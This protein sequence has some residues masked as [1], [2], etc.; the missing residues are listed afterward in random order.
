MWPPSG[1]PAAV[2]K[3]EIDAGAGSERAERGA[4]EGFLGE[5]GV[6]VGG[7]GIERGEA[8]AG[9]AERIAFAE[10]GGDAGSFD[11]DAANAAAIGEADEGS[12]LLDDA[13]EHGL[14]LGTEGPREQGTEK[15]GTGN[16]GLRDVGTK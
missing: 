15:T 12:G 10:A 4:V 2:G 9:D 7:V 5:V 16:K 13:G 11:G 6:E 1:L 14:I 8:D 3:L